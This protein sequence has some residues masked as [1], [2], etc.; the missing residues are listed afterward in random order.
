MHFLRVMKEAL[1]YDRWSTCRQDGAHTLVQLEDRARNLT[2]R[3][4]RGRDACIL[5][6]TALQSSLHM[7]ANTREEDFRASKEASNGVV[8]KI[9][10]AAEVVKKEVHF[11]R[12]E[13][14]RGVD[15]LW[16]LVSATDS[17]DR[18]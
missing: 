12:H 15:L 6:H 9:D 8:K 14:L 18:F 17:T 5:R 13:S 2:G 4:E 3:Q 11:R 16:L 7:T 10:D 1:R